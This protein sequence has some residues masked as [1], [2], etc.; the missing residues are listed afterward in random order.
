MVS[1]DFVLGFGVGFLVAAILGGFFW[2]IYIKWRRS[3]DAPDKKQPIIHLTE[4]TPRQVMEAAAA[5]WTKFFV[6]C[7]VFAL[8]SWIVV[9]I[10]LP[11]VAEFVH[12]LISNLW[13]MLFG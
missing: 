6:L 8:G 5:A 12:A 11:G 13:T 4:K 3:I 7:M 1:S 2:N 10:T 9:E